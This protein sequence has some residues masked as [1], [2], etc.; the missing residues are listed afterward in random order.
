[1]R[2]LETTN[3]VFFQKPQV[4]AS[5]RFYERKPAEIYDGDYVSQG[6]RDMCAG[7]LPKHEPEHEPESFVRPNGP[8]MWIAD[9]HPD[10]P[11]WLILDVLTGATF[12]RVRGSLPWI[13]SQMRLLASQLGGQEK[14]LY[15]RRAN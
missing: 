9:E 8:S 2:I 6:S 13:V 1:M 15:Y 5:R 12:A 3:P 4:P 11:V 10:A 7:R 14:D